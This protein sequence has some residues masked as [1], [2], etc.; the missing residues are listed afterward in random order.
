MTFSI[1]AHDPVTNQLGVAIATCALAAGRAVPWARAGVG[2]VATQ[3]QTNRMYGARGL[4]LLADG[5]P[6]REALDRLLADDPR[7]AQRQVAIVDAQ[8][9]VAAW[10]GG[11]C[12]SACGHVT[13]RG[14]SAQGNTVASRSVVPSMAEAFSD[15]SGPL[16][17]RLL[18]ALVA[19]EEAGGDIRGRQS[20]ALLVVDAEPTDEPWNGVPIDLR[21]D[22][23]ADPIGELGRLL[24]L[25]RAHE[26]G[27]WSTLMGS[28]SADTR[29]L[30][31]ALDA[32]RRGDE[33]ATR[34]ALAQLRDKP[35]IEAM[36]RRGRERGNAAHAATESG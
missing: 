32:A 6:P 26:G 34:D 13:G 10:T 3:A 36:L 23:H 14:F 18:A 12:L 2:A 19:A 21:V 9:H 35:R 30:Y 5:V 27:D 11:Y 8:G 4:E 15:S 1:V 28:A 29:G 16:G 17:E 7:P 25:Q 24:T 33:D 22:D 20:A 31:V